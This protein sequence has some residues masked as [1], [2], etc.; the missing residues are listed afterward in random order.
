[1]CVCVYVCACV[2][3]RMCVVCACVS[4][5]RVS[6]CVY[7]FPIQPNW[8]CIES[9]L[10]VLLTVLFAFVCLYAAMEKKFHYVCMVNNTR[11]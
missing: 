2:H 7:S 8:K 10:A 9:S 4:Y 5:V 3:A 11:N 1:M 6:M